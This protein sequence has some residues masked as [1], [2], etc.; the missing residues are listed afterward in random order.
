MDRTHRVLVANDDAGLRQQV[1]KALRHPQIEV[2]EA[3]NG[4]EAL[5]FARANKPEV[6]ILSVLLPAMDGL[7]VF[8]VLNREDQRGDC[9]VIL[10]S[11][12]F[13][14]GALALARDFGAFATFD[15]GYDLGGMRRAILSGLKLEDADSR[16]QAQPPAAPAD[17]APPQAQAATRKETTRLRQSKKLRRIDP[18][19][20]D[21][22]G[23]QRGAFQRAQP[24]GD[25]PPVCTPEAEAEPSGPERAE[26]PSSAAKARP[27]RRR[28]PRQP[29]TPTP[30][31]P[32]SASHEQRG[33]R[34]QRQLQPADCSDLYDKALLLLA[35]VERSPVPV[36]LVAGAKALLEHAG[37]GTAAQAAQLLTLCL[38]QLKKAEES[39]TDGIA[40]A[41]PLLAG[42]RA[43]L[44]T[45]PTER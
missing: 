7:E 43:L 9:K 23:D 31:T 12:G 29:S 22:D 3:Q 21:L 4:V 16:K 25:S 5:H 11:D 27:T 1:A 8:R 38:Q 24:S 2:L 10:V 34:E 44:E 15:K 13:L 26:R 19:G 40:G 14:T 36:A 33:E 6:V 35:D 30:G 41:A 28:E 17:G 32:T 45:P 39:D 20:R 18:L 37:A 42:A